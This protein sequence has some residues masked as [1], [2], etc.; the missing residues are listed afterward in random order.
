MVNMNAQPPEAIVRFRQ[1]YPGITPAFHVRAPG[2]VNLIGEHTD[3]NDGFVLPIAMTQALHVIAG[4][5]DDGRIVAR[6]T[7]FDNEV[8]FDVNDPGPPGPH[9]W[10]AYVRGVAAMLIRDGIRLS[11]GRLLIHS[12]VPIG[13]GVSSS[14][15][16]ELGTAT[17]LLSLAG[18]TMDPVPLALLGRR[19]EHEYAHSPCGIMDQFISALGREDHA[20]LLDC[21]SQKYEHIP[22]PTDAT[23]VVMD[24]Q[25]KHNLGASEYPLRQQQCRDGLAFLRQF[26]PQAEALRD[27]T[28]A[29]FEEY[30]D[31]ID[32]LQGRRCR[33]VIYEIDRTL[34]AADALRA[35]DLAAFGRLMYDSHASL[36][37][38]YEVS[39][40]ELDALVEIAGT[41][42][43]VYGARMTG[44]GFGGCAIALVRPDAERKLQEAVAARFNGRFEK[45]AIVYT[46]RAGSGV[47]TQKL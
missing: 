18:R 22:L 16:L 38:D 3:Y 2:R 27:I 33:H 41:V 31:G 40:P 30:C 43:G 32:E 1:L 19:A 4:P 17:A 29:Q 35:G 6:S 44:G 9:G 47:T 5:A 15:A 20:L 36:R 46:T 21:R 45:P 25:V 28:P 12:E 10:D 11:P 24:T 7:A 26:V 34:E 8:A 39:C 13:G 37:D 42:D 23:L 14:A